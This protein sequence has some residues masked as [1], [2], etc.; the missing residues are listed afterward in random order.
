M[1]AGQWSYPFVKYIAEFNFLIKEVLNSV[2]LNLQ[3]RIFQ[4]SL[5]LQKYRNSKNREDSKERN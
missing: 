5:F 4:K 3:Q 1:K 2:K